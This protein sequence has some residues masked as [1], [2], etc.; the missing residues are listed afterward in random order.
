MTRTFAQE[1]LMKK[2]RYTGEW[3]P[4]EVLEEFPNWD[5]ALGEEGAPGQ[6]E[7]TLRPQREQSKITSDTAFTR[8]S[9]AQANGE[10]KV[11]IVSVRDGKICDADVFDSPDVSWRV[12]EMDGEWHSFDQSWL[13][14]EQRSPV[15]SL[16]NPEI[17]PLVVETV[18]PHDATKAQ[19]SVTIG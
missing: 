17:F 1:C 5:Y 14:E 13:P 7:T 2:H 18:L 9:A 19:L 16:G 4:P 11:A 3:P 6:D 15:V 8:A 12:Y 10:V